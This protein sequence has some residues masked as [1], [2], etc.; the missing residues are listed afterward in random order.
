MV[1]VIPAVSELITSVCVSVMLSFVALL[2]ARGFRHVIRTM[3]PPGVE[4]KSDD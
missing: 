2:V 3:S 1:T 4:V